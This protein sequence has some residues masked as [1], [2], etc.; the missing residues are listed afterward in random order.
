MLTLDDFSDAQD[1]AADELYERDELMFIAPKGFGKCAIGYT[2]M[3]ELLS[4]G[5]LSR[6]LVLSTTQVCRETWSKEAAK[7]EHLENFPCALLAGEDIDK[8]HKAMQSDALIVVCNFENLPWLLDNYPSH[9]FD[10]LLV[11]EITKLKGVGGKYFKKLRKHLQRFK[12]RVG[13]TADAVAQESVDIYGQMLVVDCGKRLGR[14]KENF[15]R[16]YFMQIDYS[17]FKWELQPGAKELLAEKLS[18]VTYYAK[19]DDYEESL[20]EL[21]EYEVEIELDGTCQRMYMEIAKYGVTSIDSVDIEAVNAGVVSSKLR[22]I[23]N[24]GVYPDTDEAA[25]LLHDKKLHAVKDIVNYIDGHVL[26]AYQ[27]DFEREKLQEQFGY[28]VFNAK[29]PKRVNDQII[30]DWNSGDLKGLLI[31]PKSGGHGLNLQYGPCH[32]LICTSYFWS[33]D[34]WEQLLG[35]IRRRGQKSPHVNRYVVYARNTIEDCVMRQNLID[36]R[37]MSEAFNDYWKK[38]TRSV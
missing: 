21:N 37:D 22:Q 4:E 29:N 11:D 35:R 16:K 38:L 27:F 30:K 24:G 1:D 13:M 31:H 5:L 34:E 33:A 25:L 8:K 7:W 14:N 18:D 20:P 2:A 15:R 19:A 9:N 32:T 12:W 28:P 26:I 3:T 10:G 23:C 17:G 6:V 36:K